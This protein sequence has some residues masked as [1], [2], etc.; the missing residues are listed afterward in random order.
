[1]LSSALKFEN[2][3]FIMGTSKAQNSVLKFQLVQGPID[4]VELQWLEHLWNHENMF[5]TK[6]VEPINVDHST[7]SGGIIGISIRFSLT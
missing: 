3:A 4:T 2:A 6:V 1:M 7:K 5:K